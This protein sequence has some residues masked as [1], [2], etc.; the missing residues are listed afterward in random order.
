ME[1]LYLLYKQDV[2]TYLLSLTKHPTL[3][4]DLLQ[5]TFVRAIS[6]IHTFEGRSSV[7]TWLFSIARNVWLEMIR[8]EKR[9]I[10]EDDFIVQ[11][12]LPYVDEQVITNELVLKLRQLLE[13]K[14]EKTKKITIMRAEGYSFAEIAAE[15]ELSE[16]SV[17]VIEFRTKKWLKKRLEKEGFH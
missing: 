8:K 12:F 4:E 11:Y 16:S 13:E 17:R 10:Q 6:S 1:K 14:D 9:I 15:V 2:Y 3:A 5:D 7:K